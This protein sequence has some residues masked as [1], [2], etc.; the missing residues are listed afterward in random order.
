ML[1]I[2]QMSGLELPAVS[3]EEVLYVRAL[4]A[5]LSRLHGFPM[6]MQ[7]L[8]HDGNSLDNSTMLDAPMD[9]QLLVLGAFSTEVQQFEAAS[10]LRAACVHGD[11]EIAKRLLGAGANKNAEND[12]GR[13]ALMLASE[14]GHVEIARLLLEAGAG[15]DLQ[16][17]NDYTALMFAAWNGHV[18]IARMLVEA[19][20][21]KK[22]AEST[23]RYSPSVRSRERLRG[24][25]TDA[26]RSWCWQEPAE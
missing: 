20:A 13:T 11:L 17:S 15:K 23:W 16:N 5:S 6:C 4:K 10:E 21:L 3:V 22:P 8:L 26:C 2:W 7:Q 25:R 24:D 12:V 9:L 18:E 14:S 19:G 1:R